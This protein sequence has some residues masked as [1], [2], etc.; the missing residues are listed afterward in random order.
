MWRNTWPVA[1]A[2][3]FKGAPWSHWEEWASPMF[4]FWNVCRASCNR[5][6]GE[7]FRWN[8][9]LVC[10]MTTRWSGI[11]SPLNRPKVDYTHCSTFSAFKNKSLLKLENPLNSRWGGIWCRD[12]RLHACPPPTPGTSISHRN[13]ADAPVLVTASLVGVSPLLTDIKLISS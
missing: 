4:P 8:Q 3:W 6:Q 2:C 5:D 10:L 12:P 7:R 13:H 9:H 1:W 11:K